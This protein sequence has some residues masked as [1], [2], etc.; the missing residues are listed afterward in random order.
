MEKQNPATSSPLSSVLSQTNGRS[1]AGE[2]TQSLNG[3]IQFPQTP[4]QVLWWRRNF[5]GTS[6]LIPILISKNHE[7]EGLLKFLN[8]SA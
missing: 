3:H 2:N 8:A 1:Q 7:I 5:P 6:S 4:L